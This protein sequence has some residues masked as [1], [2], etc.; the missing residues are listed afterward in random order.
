MNANRRYQTFGAI[1][2]NPNYFAGGTPDKEVPNQTV[3]ASPGGI[4]AHTSNPQG[5][6]YQPSFSSSDIYAGGNPRYPSGVYGGLYNVGD[7]ASTRMGY[8]PPST[9]VAWWNN[10]QPPVQEDFELIEPMSLDPDATGVAPLST[11]PLDG[12]GE[13]S[14][15]P[16]TRFSL[17]LDPIVLLVLFLVAFIAFEFYAEALHKFLVEKMHHGQAISWQ[18]MA[19]YATVL[20]VGFVLVAY[21]V[22]VPLTTFTALN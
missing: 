18:R 7:S 10:K 19:I 2:G 15:V 13:M 9:D 22:K 11:I 6:M 4:S 16:G 1:S 14:V 5:S 17:A 3:V 8:Y 12:S 21:F 20:T